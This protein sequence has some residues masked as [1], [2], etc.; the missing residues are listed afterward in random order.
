MNTEQNIEE[1]IQQLENKIADFIEF[2]IPFICI[3]FSTTRSEVLD[4]IGTLE[5]LEEG[6]MEIS[7]V[8]RDKILIA[9]LTILE[10]GVALEPSEYLKSKI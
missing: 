6:K 7:Y 2:A 4:N 8:Y 9:T 1:Q 5:K 3:E 10:N